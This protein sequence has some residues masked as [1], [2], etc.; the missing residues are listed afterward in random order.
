M[1]TVSTDTGHNSGPGDLSWALNA[2]EQ[3]T[4][5]GWRAMHGSVQIA[6]QLTEAYYV[7]PITKSYYTGCSTGGRQGLKE[8][9]ISPD[10]F[11]GALIGSAAWDTRHL[12]PWVTRLGLLNLPE[13]DPKDFT[14]IDQFSLLASTVLRQ[15]DRVDGIAD[16]IIS[17]PESCTPDF[18]QVECGQ[19]GVDP[20]NCLSAQQIQTAKSIYADYYTESGKFVYNGQQIGSENQ[21]DIFILYGN[22]AGF[23]T[24]YEKYFLYNDPSWNWMQYNDSVVEFSET[25]NPGNATA[26]QFDISA[27]R[28]AG[29][30]VI[31][32]HGQADAVVPTR[33]SIYY[34]N[35]TLEAMG[36]NVQ[37]FLRFFLVPGMQ[38]CYL[39]PPGVNAPWMFAGEGQANAMGTTGNGWTVPGFADA[40]HDALLALIDWVENGTAVDSIIATA[41]NTSSSN[42]L[43]V[44]RQRPLCPYP[45]Q[46][47]FSGNGDP[48]LATS[49]TCQ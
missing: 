35:K 30:K 11:D 38:H 6:K 34:Y 24:S 19:P 41:W 36:N 42:Q 2:P 18:T 15:C 27:F 43:Q 7:R 1:A 9:Q 21:W 31:M 44:Y 10:S 14:T 47:T 25:K 4:D 8:I 3:Q 28:Q 16:N 46:A 48:N 40:K 37:D 49:W 23:D 5:W 29:G 32:Y 33:S 26:D 17:S 22:A 39:S 20:S 45:K 12:M 13:N